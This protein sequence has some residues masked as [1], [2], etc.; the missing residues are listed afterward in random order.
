MMKP[1]KFPEYLNLKN[2]LLLC[3]MTA[4]SASFAQDERMMPLLSN[5]AIRA[6][7]V[8][9][10]NSSES[11]KAG[12]VQ[13]NDTLFL[14][15]FDDF[16]DFA[17]WPSAG[18]WTDSSVFINA[19]FPIN[20]PTVGAAT[21][22]GLDLRGQAYVNNNVNAS[23]LCDVLTSKAI[24]LF[25]DNNGIPYNASDS[26]FMIFYFQR[27]G[28]GD[29]PET[30][31]SL[32]LQ[33]YNSVSGQWQRVWSAK[34][35][36]GGD[37][38]FT[39][40]KLSINDVN[41]R[42][43]GFR[44]RFMNYGSLTGMLDI[45]NVDYIHINKFLPPD[46]DIQRDY[47]FVYEGKSLLNNYSAVPWRHFTSL[48]QQQQQNMVKPAAELTIRNN[49]DASTF[50]IKVA[51]TVFDQYGNPTPVVGGGGLNSIVVPLNS[52]VTPPAGLLTNSF[53][54][55]AGAVDQTVFRAVYEIG[56]TSGGIVDDFPFNDTL[57]YSQH[58]YDYYS[59][60]D[61]SAE[62]AYGVSGIGAQL[63][64]K[65]DVLKS[66][67]LRAVHMF[68]AQSGLDV[69][70]QPFRL[71]VWAGTG[72]GP[73]GAPV[74]Q[75]F[76]QTPNYIDSINGFFI[77]LTDHIL[78]PAGTWY[79]GYIQTNA[80]ILNLGLDV[81]TP[82][83]NTRKFINTT[84]NWTTSQL[85]GMWMIRP[86]FSGEPL[87]TGVQD[88]FTESGLQIHPVPAVDEIVIDFKSDQT[89]NY[90]MSVFDYSGREVIQKAGFS[91]RMDVSELAS[92]FYTLQVRNSK[93]GESI[94]RKFVIS[95]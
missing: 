23:G 71:A 24:N 57:R 89:F 70:N 52:N 68:F 60:D 9:Q 74:Y 39:R 53:F 34:G 1:M 30:N 80:T 10:Q 88:P 32:Q 28:R 18:R 14:P 20:P 36:A 44:F 73:V 51:G 90:S 81:N 54:Q 83:D 47:A 40:V 69:S 33:F 31:D 37:T 93:T 92:G 48:T 17:V 6:A 42:Q 29:N 5:P 43:N 55:D 15:F 45:W 63:A 65:F 8:N 50:P 86:V 78:I 25:S 4:A 67:T 79:I 64:Y 3:F 21:F 76:N 38:S 82:A 27:K 41:Y 95:R 87:F 66:D 56:Q 19:N 2:L 7:L 58:F 46:Y 49:N 16:S 84:G 35:I 77:Y 22:D 61:G 13:V 85:P 94:T 26:I 75:K 91:S 11:S 59:Y 12:S 72:L 62:L